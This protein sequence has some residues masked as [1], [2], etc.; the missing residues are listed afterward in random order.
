MKHPICLGDATSG[1]GEVVECQLAGRHLIHGH[2]VAVVGDLATCALHPGRHAFVE[3]SATVKMDGLAVVMEGHTLACGC[4]GI[5]GKAVAAG[6]K[7]SG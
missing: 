3:G 6:V 4:H 1:G 7:S 5:A 2:P